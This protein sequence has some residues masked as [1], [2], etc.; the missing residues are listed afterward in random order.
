MNE[1]ANLVTRCSEHLLGSYSQVF[2][3]RW[4]AGKKRAP[5]V[6]QGMLN[7]ALRLAHGLLRLAWG[8]LM[9]AHARPS[10]NSSFSGSE[11]RTKLTPNM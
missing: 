3:V 11:S 7:R 4:V 9:V 2:Y 10:L 1:V 5:K 8:V 6:G